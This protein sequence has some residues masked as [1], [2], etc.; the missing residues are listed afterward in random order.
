MSDSQSHQKILIIKLG[1]LG[2]I[3]RSLYAI[4]A[5]RKRFP[6][7]R[8]DLLTRKSFVG[9]CQTIPWFDQVHTAG[10]YKPW[11]LMNWY[12][13]TK[14]M[15]SEKYDLVIDIQG[16]LRTDFYH[17]LMGSSVTHWSGSS[18]F[19]TH[20]RPKRTKPR[21]HPHQI[22]RCQLEA[23]EIPFKGEIDIDWLSE[24]LDLVKLPPRFVIL[25][26]GCSVQHPYKR[27]PASR[28]AAVS[29]ML[30]EMGI[31]S[32]VIGTKDEEETI[33][34]FVTLAPKAINLLNQTTI[35]QLAS[36]SRMAMAVI[37]N[38]T[39]PAHLMA[40]VGTPTL[41]VMSRVTI[42]ERMLP[43]GSRVSYIKKDNISDITEDEVMDS[44][45]ELMKSQNNE[46]I[47]LQP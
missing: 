38:D 24:S 26:P 32:V 44:L 8:I 35:K 3:L 37:S 42:P 7:A 2:D 11:Q 15:R 13:F 1:A 9:F 5:V 22:L 12:N 28:Y 29:R 39:G 40:M 18:P 10:Y 14:R 25:V 21:Q 19:S 46:T 6:N 47:T 4:Y 41:V 20:K 27:W 17:L 30:D 33:N 36:L 31:A 16:K 34:E 23:L 45:N 43:V